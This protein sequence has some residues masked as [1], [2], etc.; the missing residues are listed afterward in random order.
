MHYPISLY[1]FIDY[2]IELTFTQTSRDCYRSD[3]LLSLNWFLT[4]YVQDI[5]YLR[6]TLISLLLKTALCYSK[7]VFKNKLYFDKNKNSI[8]LYEHITKICQDSNTVKERYWDNNN[9]TYKKGI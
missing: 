3:P 1:K 8:D 6:Q 9:Y 5:V 4:L 7:I 2:F